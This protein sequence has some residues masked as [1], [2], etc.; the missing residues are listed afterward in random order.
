MNINKYKGYLIYLVNKYNIK[1][2]AL[3]GSWPIRTAG[4]IIWKTG[5]ALEVVEHGYVARRLFPT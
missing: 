5:A 4:A 3:A 2:H 1:I